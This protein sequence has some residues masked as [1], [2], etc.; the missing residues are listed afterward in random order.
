M[1]ITIDTAEN[2]RCIE[3][4]RKD[5]AGVDMIK[6][7]VRLSITA[8]ALV[9]GFSHVA[10]AQ[11]ADDKQRVRTVSIP[12]SIYTK[13]ELEQ[14]QADELLQVERL[15][16]KENGVEQEILSIRSRNDVPLS[17]AVLI[18]DDL[19]SDFNLQLKDLAE[20]IVGLPRGSRVMVAYLRGGSLDV[21]QRFTEDLVKASKSFRVVFSDPSTAPRSPY[22]GVSDTL[23][24]FEALPA[25]RRA[26]LLISNGLDLSN[27]ISSSS[28]SSSQSLQS[29]IL[30]A[31]RRSVAVFSIF[32]ATT[33]GN[34]AGS[35]ALSNGQGSLSVL[36]DET[37]GRT[38]GSGS[39]TPINFQPFL[40]QLNVLMGRQFLL[41][42]L[43]T[44]M[45]RGYYKVEVKST[46][47]EVKI[48][49]PRGYY[50]R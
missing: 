41:S 29:A 35:V 42:Y 46:N 49:H 22:D 36:A 16:V 39:F 34:P 38:F 28:P 7:F 10:I 15:W 31:Q 3:K 27:G 12:I 48:E 43:T 13:S 14:G 2:F 33:T 47:P 23:D 24:R 19:T 8:A 26:I 9:A 5:R 40:R 17:L 45:K 30:K 37:G 44:N 21:R 32:A 1:L 20:F 25:G 4:R 6:L 18:Q 50:Y 11:K